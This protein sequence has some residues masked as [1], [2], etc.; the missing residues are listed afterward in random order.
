MLG[1]ILRSLLVRYSKW[2]SK[3]K[4]LFSAFFDK[5][6]EIDEIERG[7]EYSF[8]INIDTVVEDLVEY[9]EEDETLSQL[10][11]I[12]DVIFGSEEDE[13]SSFDEEI[14]EEETEAE[15]EAYRRALRKSKR[16]KG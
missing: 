12:A 15:E 3:N 10:L 1:F 9:M 4:R 14:A 11:D 5:Y 6:V 8:E 16:Q 13:D 2:K 7:S